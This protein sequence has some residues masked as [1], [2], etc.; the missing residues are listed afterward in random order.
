[1]IAIL[2]IYKHIYVQRAVNF[3]IFFEKFPTDL[4]LLGRGSRPALF[5]LRDIDIQSRTVKAI[6]LFFSGGKY[7][8]SRRESARSVY[9]HGLVIQRT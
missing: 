3:F 5:R 6:C 1:M 9:K 8:S 4:S 7:K 2:N